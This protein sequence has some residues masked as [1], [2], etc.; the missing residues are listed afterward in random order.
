MK[1]EYNNFPLFFYIKMLKYFY[2]KG[3]SYEHI[4]Y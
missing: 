4:Y 3:E 2:K 1:G